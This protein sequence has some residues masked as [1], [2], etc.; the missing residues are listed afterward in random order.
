[1][2]DSPRKTRTLI[3]GAA[4]GP[5]SLV[6]AL[7][8]TSHSVFVADPFGRNVSGDKHNVPGADVDLADRKDVFGVIERGIQELGGLDSFIFTAAN[9]MAVMSG[10]GQP[11]RYLSTDYWADVSQSLIYG[12]FYCTQAVLR[13]MVGAK[14]GR[15]IYVCADGMVD[16]KGLDVPLTAASCSLLALSSSIAGSVFRNGMT[17]NAVIA[18]YPYADLTEPV[19]PSNGSL[20][21]ELAYSQNARQRYQ[22]DHRVYELETQHG[23]GW[24]ESLMAFIRHLESVESSLINGSV[25]RLANVGR[26]SPLIRW[27]C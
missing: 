14:G 23:L 5:S 18:G 26:E 17:V 4:R 10:N 16:G 27:T 15:I 20:R 8:A 6:G 22:R 19:S 2:T 1:M 11:E 3:I 7:E 13:H 21:E 25:F 12:G 24:A 9:D